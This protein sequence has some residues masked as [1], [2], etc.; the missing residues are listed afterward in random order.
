MK[1]GLSQWAPPAFSLGRPGNNQSVPLYLD[2]G[3]GTAG[4]T[5][6]AVIGD[7]TKSWLMGSAFTVAGAA[8]L[9]LVVTKKP[10][11]VVPAAIGGSL[12]FILDLICAQIIGPMEPKGRAA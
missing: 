8:F 2:I 7:V 11:L 1:K 9:G 6:A 4:F 3:L 12:P 10:R 5:A